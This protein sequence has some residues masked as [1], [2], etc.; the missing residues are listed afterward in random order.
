MAW[1]AFSPPPP[2]GEKQLPSPLL[3]ENKN[4]PPTSIFRGQEPLVRGLPT[5]ALLSWPV[6]GRAKGGPRP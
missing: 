5:Q 1:A 3:F 6:L 2:P 4:Q